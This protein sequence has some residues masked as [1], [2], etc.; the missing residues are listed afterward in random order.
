MTFSFKLDKPGWNVAVQFNKHN[1]F[2]I[3]SRS[4]FQV[5]NRYPVLALETSQDF[6]A[7]AIPYLKNYVGGEILVFISNPTDNPMYSTVQVDYP[8]KTLSFNV[9]YSN[10]QQS[11]K[12]VNYC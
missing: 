1:D 6:S 3:N 5:T 8:G 9:K 11:K 10:Y 4:A 7:L 12:K 2:L